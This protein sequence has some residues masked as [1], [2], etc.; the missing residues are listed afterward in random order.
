MMIIVSIQVLALCILHINK[1]QGEINAQPAMG[2]S[3]QS[4]I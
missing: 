1:L 2:G 4:N 3:D